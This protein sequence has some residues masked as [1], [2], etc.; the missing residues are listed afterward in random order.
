MVESDIDEALRTLVQQISHI[1]NTKS[2][3]AHAIRHLLPAINL[4]KFPALASDFLE[5]S[6]V[7]TVSPTNLSGLRIAAVDGGLVKKRYQSL[8]L[9]MKRAVGVV[10]SF[11]AEDSPAVE[12]YP[13]PFPNPVIKPIIATLSSNEV[14][15]IASLERLLSELTTTIGIIDEYHTDIVLL[16]GSLLFHPHD[17]PSKETLANEKFQEVL[18]LYKQIYNKV[19]KGKTTLVGVVKDSRS[20]KFATMLGQVLPHILR[21]PQSFEK[22]KDIDYRWL[23][24]ILRDCDLLGSFLKAGERSCIFRHSAES[25]NFMVEKSLSKWTSSIMV[26]YLKTVSNDLPVRFE[27]LTRSDEA[28]AVVDKALAAILPLSSLHQEYGMPTPIVEADTR[29]RIGRN[30]AEMIVDRLMALSGLAYATLERR[31]SRNPFG[32]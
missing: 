30:E 24:N 20:R 7:S 32:G 19:S 9:I 28:T 4:G 11:Q 29:A 26:T 12:F 1:E 18:A 31:R 21:K 6:L 22:M 15:Q 27:V 23:L 2:G 25:N 5:S 14:D 16:D 3:F 17:R 8:D 10:F 13:S